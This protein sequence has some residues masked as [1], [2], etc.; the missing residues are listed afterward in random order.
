MELA[1]PEHIV[2]SFIRAMNAWEIETWESQRAAKGTAQP[3]A[4][5]L[6]STRRLA[7]V[8]LRYCTPRERLQGR[9]G[10]FQHP[11]EYDCEKETI[12][13]V[14]VNGST[15]YVETKR[16]AVLAGGLYRYKLE[17][18]KQRWLIDTLSVQTENGWQVTIL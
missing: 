16:V 3:S 12:H 9:N 17:K 15:A 2:E 7:D 11:P 13:S 18:L 10:T 14:N 8:F 5:Q 1:H 6:A 4:Y